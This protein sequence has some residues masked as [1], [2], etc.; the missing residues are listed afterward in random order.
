MVAM[1]MVGKKIT[2]GIHPLINYFVDFLPPKPLI[3]SMIHDVWQK[4]ACQYII[5]INIIY[6]D[7]KIS[8]FVVPRVIVYG[9]P[10][11]G[12]HTVVSG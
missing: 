7:L 9:P 6:T 10:T 2:L 8:S 11:S 5:L 12:Q 1:V 4:A 3:N